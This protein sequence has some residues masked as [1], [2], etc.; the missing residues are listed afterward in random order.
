MNANEAKA[1]LK[2]TFDNAF[3]KAKGTAKQRVAMARI[4]CSKVPTSSQDSIS[5]LLWATDYCKSWK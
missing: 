1:I 2:E 5:V 4:C 3:R